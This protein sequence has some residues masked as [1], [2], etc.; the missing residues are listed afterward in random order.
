MPTDHAQQTPPT[1]AGNAG[2][3]DPSAAPGP[4]TAQ[5]TQQPLAGL[6]IAVTASRRA[7][8][9]ADA[10]RRR[11][12][13]VL[14]APTMRIVPTGADAQLLTDTRR[15]LDVRPAL[16]FVTT[17][18]GFTAWLD[19]LSSADPDL[20]QAAMAYLADTR[21]ICRGAK[22]RGAVRGRGLPDAPAAPLET[23]ASMVDVALA[24]GVPAGP[25]GLQRHG[26]IH[27][28]VL[29]R[30]ADEGE[31]HDLVVVAPYRWEPPEELDPVDELVSGICL[32]RIDAVTFTAAPSVDALFARADEL[33]RRDDV[34]DAL[35][36]D[37]QA[38]AVGPVTAEPLEAEGIT[39]IA[40]QRQRMGAMIQLMA[41]QLPER[42]SRR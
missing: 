17:A 34:V 40:P 7:D 42:V 35:R 18:Q 11:G 14:L 26:Y 22:A 9:Q 25:V 29:T 1:A 5:G 2:S 41:E 28:D 10:L 20:A 39:P 32:R 6:R 37:V 38:V 13:D 30:L 33:G 19:A 21:I 3:A 27:P 23:S 31:G 4:T 8:D 15:L 16:F 36:S 12:A 24:E